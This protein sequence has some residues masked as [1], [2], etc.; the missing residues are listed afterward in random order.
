MSKESDNRIG[1]KAIAIQLANAPNPRNTGKSGY[2]HQFYN[3]PG[4]TQIAQLV[5]SNSDASSTTSLYEYPVF[6]DSHTYDYQKKPRE[7][8]GHI[9]GITNQNKRF[10]GVVAHN[11]EDG[12]PNKG[13]MHWVE[14]E[15]RKQ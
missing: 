12:N 3:E 15:M 9:R 2:P 5:R 8:P 10:K 1:V 13:D 11:G 7:K 14:K 4:D 6:S